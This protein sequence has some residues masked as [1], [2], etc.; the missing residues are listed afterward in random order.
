MDAAQAYHAC[1]PACRARTN[2]GGSQVS[3]SIGLDMAMLKHSVDVCAIAR[4]S[5]VLEAAEA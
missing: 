2:H 5:V 1:H 3:I 4:S